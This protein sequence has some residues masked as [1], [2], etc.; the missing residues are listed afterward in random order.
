MKMNIVLLALAFGVISHCMA[1]ENFDNKTLFL[2]QGEHNKMVNKTTASKMCNEYGMRLPSIANDLFNLLNHIGHWKTQNVLLNDGKSLIARVIPSLDKQKGMFLIE[3]D[4]G[5]LIHD[6][7]CSDLKTE[8][9]LKCHDNNS[10]I[11]ILM[12]YS[13]F[14]SLALVIT[15]SILI[16]CKRSPPPA[17]ENG[18]N[19]KR[20]RFSF[21]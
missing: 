13:I 15:C 12:V 1:M 16:T 5:D 14:T 19:F 20:L 7:V 18:E 3:N 9:D 8:L 6:V 17:A 10:I 11:Y 2:I 21:L 4:H